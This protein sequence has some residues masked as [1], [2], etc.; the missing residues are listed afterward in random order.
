MRNGVQTDHARELDWPYPSFSAFHFTASFISHISVVSFSALFILS[1]ICS[2][3][4]SSP[5]FAPIHPDHLLIITL[6]TPPHPSSSYSSSSYSPPPPHP[7]STAP[8]RT[9]SSSFFFPPRYY[10]LFLS[11]NPFS[12]S[13]PPLFHYSPLV[14]SATL[15]VLHICCSTYFFS[16]P[17][18]LLQTLLCSYP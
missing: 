11:S 18:F 10:F 8:H 17:Y 1:F 3:S 13:H 5:V 2:Y 12:P 7:T 14:L 15:P 6:S 9:P 4:V 16:K